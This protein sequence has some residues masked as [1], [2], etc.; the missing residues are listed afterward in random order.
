M[1]LISNRLLIIHRFAN[2][3]TVEY[4]IN[5]HLTKLFHKIVSSKDSFLKWQFLGQQW[6]AGY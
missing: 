5:S 6:G 1:E 3:I 2:Y 4:E